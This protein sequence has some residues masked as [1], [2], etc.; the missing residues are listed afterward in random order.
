MNIDIEN[1]EPHK[2]DMAEGTSSKWRKG[3]RHRSAWSVGDNHVHRRL[4]AF[5]DGTRYR[6]TSTYSPELNPKG[7]LWYEIREKSSRTMHSNPCMLCAPNSS[8][9]SSTLS[10]IPA[11]PDPPRSLTSST[12]SDVE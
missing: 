2:F 9:P 6:L 8:S 4:A 5:T 7:N 10:A 12:H 1:G 11:S 3:D